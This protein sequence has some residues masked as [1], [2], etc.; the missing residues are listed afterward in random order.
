MTII[1]NLRTFFKNPFSTIIKKYFLFSMLLFSCSINS[2]QHYQNSKPK[3]DIRNYFNGDLKVFGI[4]KN[5]QGEITRKFTANINGEWQGNKGKLTEH[6]IFDDGETQDR[7]WI[8]QFEDDNKFT[9]TA[10]DVI[11]TAYGMQSGNSLK[12]EY[13]LDIP[14]KNSKIAINIED[15]LY[16]IDDKHLINESKLKKFGFTVGYLTIGFIKK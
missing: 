7:V 1:T 4:L 2:P 15:W 13:K 10:G 5:R 12:M 16:L 8:I 14:Y 6:F 9:A 3:L 11:G